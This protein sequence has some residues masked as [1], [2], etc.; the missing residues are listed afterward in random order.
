MID[1]LTPD[2]VDSLQRWANVHRSTP[3]LLAAVSH[4]DRLIASHRAQATLID[5]LQNRC[6]ECDSATVHVRREVPFWSRT[7]QCQHRWHGEHGRSLR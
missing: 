7:Q 1:I 5:Q 3:T 4:L 2:E 6:P